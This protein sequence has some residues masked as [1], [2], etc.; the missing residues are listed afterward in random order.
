MKKVLVGLCLVI[1]IFIIVVLKYIGNVNTLGNINQKITEAKKGTGSSISFNCEKGDNL[2]IKY[3]STVEK[4]K[5]ILTLTNLS[6]DVEKR[7]E[8]ESSCKNEVKEI[9][10]DKG[11]EYE[12]FTEYNN[13]IGKYKI[14]AYK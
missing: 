13:F 14:S 8:I 1:I 2:K 4:G 3:T 12:L 9:N 11:G 7:F 10:I 6:K 5:L